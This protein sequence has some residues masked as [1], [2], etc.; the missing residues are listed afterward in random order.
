MTVGAN[1]GMKMDI[2]WP[3]QAFP[4]TPPGI[5]VTYHGGSIRLSVTRYGHSRVLRNI[6]KRAR[7]LGYDAVLQPIEQW[8]AWEVLYVRYEE[9]TKLIFLIRN[10]IF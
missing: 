3:S 1:Y 8:V 6:T 10:K 9:N 7:E 4:V 5:R 2:V